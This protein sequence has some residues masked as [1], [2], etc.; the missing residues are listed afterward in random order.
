MHGVHDRPLRAWWLAS[1]ARF[2]RAGS[3]TTPAAAEV[4]VQLAVLDVDRDQTISPGLEMPLSVPPPWG[5]YIAGW[6]SL[7]APAQPPMKC[8][9][10]AEPLI[11]KTQT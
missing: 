7:V 1:G 11:R 8:A 10:G 5:K 3:S 6:R 4:H 2:P 9:G